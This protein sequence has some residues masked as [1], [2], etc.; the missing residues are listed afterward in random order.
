VLAALHGPAAGAGVG[1]AL[2][3]DLRVATPDATLVPAFAAIGLVPDSGTSWLAVQLLGYARA[4]AWLT[5]GRRLDAQEARELGLV[6]EIVAPEALLDRTR[7]RAE[8]LAATP[9]RSVELTKRLLQSAGSAT[10]AGQL[11]LERE[12]QQA[13]SEHPAYR[14]RVQAFLEQRR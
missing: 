14:E 7:A 4:F 6:D 11:D 13:A 9:G 8:E 12:L 2:A 10:L 5:S 1:L 3:C